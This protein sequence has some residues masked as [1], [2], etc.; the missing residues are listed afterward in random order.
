MEDLI[1]RYSTTH[2]WLLLKL[3]YKRY[4]G[5]AIDPTQIHRMVKQFITKIDNLVKNAKHKKCKIHLKLQ[6]WHVRFL[7]RV[8][9]Y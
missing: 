3:I 9:I 2:Q 1:L 4:K 6:L 7:T 8:S 5:C